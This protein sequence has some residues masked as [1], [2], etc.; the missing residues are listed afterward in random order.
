LNH[1]LDL[2]YL[3]IRQFRKL[4]PLVVRLAPDRTKLRTTGGGTF[5]PSIV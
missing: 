5:I 3:G 1:H 4:F 2:F